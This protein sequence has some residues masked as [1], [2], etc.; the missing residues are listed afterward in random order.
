MR[1]DEARERIAVEPD[2]I[3][4]KRFD[5]SLA[6]LVNKY[7]GGVPNRVVAAALMVTEDDVDD[8]YENIILKLRD[9]LKIEL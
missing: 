7:P 5:Y 8:I 1:G 3:F 4:L 9:I 2:F 6:A